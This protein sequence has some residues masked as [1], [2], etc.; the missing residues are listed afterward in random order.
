MQAASRQRPEGQSEGQH[1]LQ[2]RQAGRAAEAEASRP[3]ARAWLL[4]RCT[5][6]RQLG[7]AP[8]CM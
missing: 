2:S 1:R 6:L 4:V 5:L 8:Q 7:P 3:R